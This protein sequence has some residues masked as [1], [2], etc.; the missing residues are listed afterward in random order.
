M[1]ILKEAVEV[2][3]EGLESLMGERIT[4]YCMN[5]IYTGKLVG[6]NATCVKLIEASIVYDTG[7]AAE[8]QYK[9][10]E[11]FPDAWY[12]QTGAIESFGLFK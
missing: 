9:V 12:V 2:S 11:P 1:K 5:Y 4:L 3:G 6:V 10:K 8:N 7:P